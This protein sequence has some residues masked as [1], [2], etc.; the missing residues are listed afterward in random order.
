[1]SSLGRAFE[2]HLAAGDDATAVSLA[3][4]EVGARARRRGGAGGRGAWC[5]FSTTQEPPCHNAYVTSTQSRR[6]ATHNAQREA[7]LDANGGFVFA[8]L[9]GC[10]YVRDE[11]RCAQIARR[12]VRARMMTSHHAKS[13]SRPLFSTTVRAPP[14]SQPPPRHVRYHDELYENERLF[15]GAWTSRAL[16]P[17][18]VGPWSDAAGHLHGA[19]RDA[20][21]PPSPRSDVVADWHWLS[22]P[23]PPPHSRDAAAAVAAAAAAGGGWADAEG[24]VGV[25]ARR[26]AVPPWLAVSRQFHSLIRIVESSSV[27]AESS[28]VRVESSSVRVEASSMRVEP[29]LMRAESSLMR[30][31][32]HA[33]LSAALESAR[34]T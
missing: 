31:E 19:A 14:S 26:R 5:G 16:L 32:S 2:E 12:R 9:G 7:A 17:T 6:D 15:F 27:R 29:S 4:L 28:S 13:A 3:R 30:A 11:V 10:H 34:W 24:W 23:P 21:A 22:P 20:L 33:Q 18:D 25:L 1:M 8:R